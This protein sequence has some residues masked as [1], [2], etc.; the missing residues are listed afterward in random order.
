MQLHT[1]LLNTIRQEFPHNLSQQIYV[2]NEAFE[3]VRGAQESLLRLV[4]GC[5]G[6]SNPH[7][8]A[9][10]LAERIVHAYRM[11]ENPPTETAIEMLKSEVKKY[12]V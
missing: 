5:A 1:E 11:S 10:E 4:N 2:S 9:T 12:L 8:S 3:Y 7:G 6:Q